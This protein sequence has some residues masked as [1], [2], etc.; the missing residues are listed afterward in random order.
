M[1]QNDDLSMS[2]TKKKLDS[3]RE[4]GADYLCVGCPWCQVQ[5]DHVQQMI[6][7]RE[8]TNHPLP[9]LVYPQL[10][11]LAMGLNKDAL[12]LNEN[13]INISAIENFYKQEKEKEK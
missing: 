12:G 11:G 13:I 3:G 7:S 5:F 10:L 6:S 1:G 2:L 8:G 9:S 4:A